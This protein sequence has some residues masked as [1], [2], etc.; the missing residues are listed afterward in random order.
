MEIVSTPK[1]WARVLA[2]RI[3]IEEG[4]SFQS[5]GVEKWK[6]YLTEHTIGPQ[7]QDDGDLDQST[8]DQVSQLLPRQPWP[9]AIHVSVADKLGIT[10]KLASRCIG[11]LIKL[12]VFQKQAGGKV[13]APVDTSQSGAVSPPTDKAAQS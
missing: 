8:L 5:W 6:A 10:E 2:H 1:T 3:T 11:R 7:S 13:I 4:N 12:G 9:Q